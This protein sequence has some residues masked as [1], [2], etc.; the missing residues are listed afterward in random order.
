[1]RFVEGAKAKGH[2]EDKL[3][4]IWAD[5]EAFAQYAF[6]KSHSTCYAVLAFQTA[7]L[8]AHYPEEFMSAVLNAEKSIENLTFYMSECRRMGIEV[9]GPDVNESQL[10]FAVSKENAIRFGLSAIKGVGEGAAAE[11]IDNRAEAGLYSSVFDLTKRVNLKAVNKRV[12]EALA[13]SG[14]FDCFEGIHR[15]Q[16]FHRNISDESNIIEKSIKYGAT[17][18]NNEAASQVSLF[19]G[20]TDAELPEPVIPACDPWELEEKLEKEKTVVGMYLSGHPLDKYSVEMHELCTHQLRDLQNLDDLMGKTI[21]IGGLLTDLM[22]RETYNGGLMAIFNL[23]DY[24]GRN[25]FRLNK[26]QYPNFRATLKMEK[27]LY[28]KGTVARRSWPKDSTELEFVIQQIATLREMRSQLLYGITLAIPI[29]RANKEFGGK[30]QRF[31]NEYPGD[32][33]LKMKLI[34]PEAKIQLPM[35]SNQVKIDLRKEVIDYLNR[36]QLSYHLE[37]QK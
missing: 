13:V 14:A 6:N 3:N 22:E 32:T 20:G 34:D 33:R 5:W 28:I 4:K 25:E 27:Y 7:Y 17:Y 10:F 30:L 11:I 12:M 29:S 36:E 15:A 26:N 21:I 9:M 8:K 35:R 18:Q 24:T 1:A 37:V 19:G 16:Y 31:L 2:P 23:E